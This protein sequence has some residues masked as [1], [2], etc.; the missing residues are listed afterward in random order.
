[1][2]FNVFMCDFQFLVI[3]FFLSVVF[4]SRLSESA[5]F[6][7]F[8]LLCFQIA[9]AFYIFDSKSLPSYVLSQY[10]VSNHAFFNYLYNEPSLRRWQR[11][12]Q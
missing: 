2:I 7:T 1:M 9:S 3:L 10:F 12:W 11:P 5:L 4:S 8:S 6:L